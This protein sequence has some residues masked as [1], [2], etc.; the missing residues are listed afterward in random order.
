MAEKLLLEA[1]SLF[2]FYRVEKCEVIN[3]GAYFT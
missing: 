3:N 1:L 2:G